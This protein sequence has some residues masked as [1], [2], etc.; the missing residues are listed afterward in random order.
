MKSIS[1]SRIEGNARIEEEMITMKAVL[2]R[3]Q[4]SKGFVSLEV[5]MIAGIIIVLGAAIMMIFNGS[6]KNITETANNQ[7]MEA[8]DTMNQD[9]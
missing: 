1:D 7:L 9:N 2:N 5:I 6:A 4:N 8:N 3:I